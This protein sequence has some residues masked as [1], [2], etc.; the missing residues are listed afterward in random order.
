MGMTLNAASRLPPTALGRIGFA[1]V[2]DT[3][4]GGIGVE[5]FQPFQADVRVSTRDP[6]GTHRTHE[7]H[8]SSEAMARIDSNFPAGAGEC[9]GF[10]PTL[11]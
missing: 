3:E 2:F 6:D 5:L 9:P 7:A 1:L 10:D 11:R 4:A 8:Y